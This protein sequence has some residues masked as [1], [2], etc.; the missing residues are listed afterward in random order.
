GG[1]MGGHH[2]GGPGGMGGNHNGGPNG[3]GGGKHNGGPGNWRDGPGGRHDGPGNW[4]DGPRRGDGP[5]HGGNRNGPGGGDRWGHVGV[6][7]KFVVAPHRFH[8]GVYR[9]PGN[10]RYRRLTYGWRLPPVY[11]GRNYWI[12]SYWEYD[13]FQPEYWGRWVRY[14]NDAVLIDTRTGTVIDVRYDV[15][16]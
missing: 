15:F 4:R 12:D 1:G 16:Y 2:N 7:G 3:P 9:G 14:G 13:L 8:G 11:W 5:G 6:R 10:W